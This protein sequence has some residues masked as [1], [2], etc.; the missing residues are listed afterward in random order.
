MAGGAVLHISGDGHLIGTDAA[1]QDDLPDGTGRKPHLVQ[2][3]RAGSSP[4]IK[5]RDLVKNGVAGRPSHE[6]IEEIE[7]MTRIVVR[8]SEISPVCRNPA[9]I[10]QFGIVGI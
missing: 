2:S 10:F 9:A 4:L 1:R 6:L 7:L 3:S 5:E 8:L